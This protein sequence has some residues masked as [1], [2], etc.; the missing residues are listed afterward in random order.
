M[1]RS[2]GACHR[3]DQ[4]DWLGVYTRGSCIENEPF[5]RNR[6]VLALKTPKAPI[7]D[8]SVVSAL[9]P[10]S[11]GGATPSAISSASP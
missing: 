7:D 2:F 10:L 5:S 8:A 11:A 4:R 9:A 6:M 1:R 3:L